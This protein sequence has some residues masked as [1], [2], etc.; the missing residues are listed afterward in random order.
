[1]NRHIPIKDHPHLVRDTKTNMILN[2]NKSNQKRQ[3]LIEEQHVKDREEIEKLQ[4]DVSEIKMMLQ[5]IL[6]NGTHAK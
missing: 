3:R 2:I 4:S 5:K 1:M 6:E